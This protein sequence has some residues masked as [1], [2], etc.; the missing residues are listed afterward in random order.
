MYLWRKLTPASRAQLLADRV[1]NQ[2]PWHSPPR[3]PDDSR[4]LFHLTAACY[5]H[6]PLIGAST[7]RM[8]AFT[9]DL[10]ALLAAAAKHTFAWCVLANHYHLLVETYNLRA[11]TQA[12]GKLHG[13]IS[14]HWNG[15]ENLRGRKC[16]QR[17]ADRAFRSDRHFWATMNYVHHNPVRHGYVE[18]WTDWPWS[19]AHDF[20]R[21]VGR[22]EAARLWREYPLM[23]YG[24][25]WDT[26]VDPPHVLPPHVVPPLG[27]MNG[28]RP[29]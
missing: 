14:F 23:D 25:G 2:R 29:E 19:S 1:A 16:F 27:G 12:L 20:L 11:T 10:L 6:A 15:V 26:R 28:E 13:R 4:T 5:E 9:R 24:Y 7:E 21:G 17:V 18:K 3:W 8:D 22:E